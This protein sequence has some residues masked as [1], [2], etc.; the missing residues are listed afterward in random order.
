M[1]KG[2]TVPDPGTGV[3]SDRSSEVSDKEQGDDRKDASP[4]MSSKMPGVE[5][6]H[7]GNADHHD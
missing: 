6:G 5:E 4:Q 1:D 7:E 3:D 2:G